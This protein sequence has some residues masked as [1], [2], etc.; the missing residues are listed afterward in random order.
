M[1]ILFNGF[2]DDL[3]CTAGLLIMELIKD[4]TCDSHIKKNW[5]WSLWLHETYSKWT[6]ACLEGVASTSLPQGQHIY[7]WTSQLQNII[8]HYSYTCV[9][10]E[11]QTAQVCFT[12]CIL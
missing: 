12:I 10:S 5:R 1:V 6:R 8:Q 11:N 3:T 7:I 2:K 4:V 9:C